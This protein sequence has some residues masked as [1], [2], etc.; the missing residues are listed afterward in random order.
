MWNLFSIQ[1]IDIITNEIRANDVEESGKEY[2]QNES[3]EA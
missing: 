3:S 2:Y 1:K